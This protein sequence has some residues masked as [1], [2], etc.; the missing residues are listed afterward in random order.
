M[1]AQKRPLSK[2]YSKA[3]MLSHSVSLSRARRRLARILGS[4]RWRDWKLCKTDL[5]IFAWELK[6]VKDV[7][8][9]VNPKRKSKSHFIELSKIHPTPQSVL[10]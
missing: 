2:T 9:T 7:T 6:R 5:S 1:D 4:R 3:K 10:F 8:C